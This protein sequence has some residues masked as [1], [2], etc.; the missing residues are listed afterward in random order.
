M[1]SCVPWLAHSSAIKDTAE[2]KENKAAKA[3]LRD[4]GDAR[5]EVML[6]SHTH[7]CTPF[8]QPIALPDSHIQSS[9]RQAPATPYGGW[10]S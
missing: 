4:P 3:A 7:L 1:W 9:S 6:A 10:T 5:E 2:D 8:A